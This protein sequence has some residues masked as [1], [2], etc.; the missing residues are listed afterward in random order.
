MPTIIRALGRTLA[1]QA[2]ALLALS[3]A[4]SGTAYAVVAKNSV[5][6]SSIKNGQVKT[7]DLANNAVKPRKLAPNAVD[8][9]KVAD[10]TLTGADIDESSLSRVPTALT[11]DVGG[12]VWSSPAGACVPSNTTY[13]KCTEKTFNLP[14]PATLVLVGQAGIAHRSNNIYEATGRCRYRVNGTDSAATPV[15]R[16]AGNQG[17]G[18]EEYAPLLHTTTVPAGQV[19]VGIWCIDVFY[20]SFEGVKFMALAATTPPPSS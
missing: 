18:W 14:A 16:N 5:V 20:S 13:E 4:V 7:K 6:S 12:Q 19:T 3:I 8:G 11:A 1:S 15:A 2:I 9:S 10:G 17:G